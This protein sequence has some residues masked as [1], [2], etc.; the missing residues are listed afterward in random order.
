MMVAQP[1]PKP[2]FEEFIKSCTPLLKIPELE[3]QMRERIRTIVRELLDFQPHTDPAK[4]LKQFIQ[5]DKNFLGVL[6][7]LTNFSQEKFLRVLA[8]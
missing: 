7:A 5:K 3:A 6:L 8:A 2:T 1:S 4:N